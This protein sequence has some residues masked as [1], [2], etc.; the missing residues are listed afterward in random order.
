MMGGN[1]RNVKRVRRQ[2]YASEIT[3]ENASSAT[4]IGKPDKGDAR[5]KTLRDSKGETNSNHWV[6]NAEGVSDTESLG[7]SKGVFIT[8]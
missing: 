7:E 4:S 3:S 2:T 6:R 5:G 8:P 1:V